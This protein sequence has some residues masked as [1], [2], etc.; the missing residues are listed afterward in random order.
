MS[1]AQ[2]KPLADAAESE[3][4]RMRGNSLHGNR[5]SLSREIIE[6]IRGATVP[7]EMAEKEG[8]EQAIFR[9]R[10]SEWR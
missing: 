8:R 5:V 9:Q 2:R 3:T 4:L 7:H 10:R 6:P 1:D